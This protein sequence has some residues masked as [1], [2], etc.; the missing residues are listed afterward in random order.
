M[1]EQ[2]ILKSN[3]QGYSSASWFTGS[4]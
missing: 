1:M 2:I 3:T 4:T